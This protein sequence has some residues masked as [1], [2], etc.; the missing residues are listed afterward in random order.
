M[1]ASQPLNNPTPHSN[2]GNFD[3]SSC[4]WSEPQKNMVIKP[5]GDLV[6]DG[7]FV[8][9]DGKPSDTGHNQA[10][11]L[12]HADVSLY[13]ENSKSHIVLLVFQ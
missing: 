12:P 7:N 3:E 8:Y 13:V 4:K 9:F 5:S 2:T 1:R 11:I 10:S 6:C